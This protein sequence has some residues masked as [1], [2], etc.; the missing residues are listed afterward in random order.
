MSMVCGLDL[1]R[2][3]I[4]F[5]ALEVESGESWR[6]RVWQPDRERFRRWLR[7]DV[8]RRAQGGPVALA[9]EGCTG[10]RYVVEEIDGGGVRGACRRAGRHPSGAGPQASRQDRSHRCRGCSASCGRRGICRS[11]GSRRADVLEWRERVRLYKSLVDQRTMWCQRIHAEL[12]QHGVAVPEGAIRSARD[13]GA[14]RGRRRAAVAGGPAAD[15]GRL[16]DDRRDRCRGPAAQA[17]PATLRCPPARVSG[18]GRRA[19]RDRRVD[20]GGGVVRA[21]RLPTVLPLRPSGA[22]HRPRRHR[23]LRRI[24][25]APVGISH[26]K[27]PRRCGGRCTKRR[28]TRRINAAPTT[29]TTRRSRNVTTARSPRSRSPASSPAAATTSCATSTPTSSTRCPTDT[30]WRQRRQAR[31]PRTSGSTAVSSCH[32]RARQH[33]VLDGLRTLTRPRS[34]HRGT[35]NHD[36]CRRRHHARRAPR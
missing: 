18:V 30:C 32:R 25:A 6:G 2:R 17:R 1:H 31:P 15:P 4:T 8:H 7:D 33:L 19:V 14:A 22:P 26:G 35:P 12:Y 28:R 16:S 5:D 11:R 21:R 3:Q 13:P 29:T 23:R 10:W 27:D 34:H 9:V 24:G 20:R 36:C